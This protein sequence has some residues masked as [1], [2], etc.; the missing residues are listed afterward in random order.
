[1]FSITFD[2]T[3]NCE[4]GLKLL[5]SAQSPVLNIGT[6]FAILSLSGNIPLLNA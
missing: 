6:T 5:V 1:M 2:I 4:I 3:G